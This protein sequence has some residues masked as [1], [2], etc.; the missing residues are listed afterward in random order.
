MSDL[1]HLSMD[2]SDE[3]RL[4][5]AE[6]ILRIRA[7]RWINYSRAESA[8]VR[9]AELLEYPQRDRMPCLLLFGAT[10]MGKTKILRK[11]LRD[12]PD[13]FDHSVGITT[14][15]VVSMQMPPEPDEKSFYEEMLGSLQAPVRVSTTTHHLRRVTRD[16]LRFVGARMIV[17]DEVH[18]LLAGSYRQQRVLLNTLRFLATD[19][20]VPLVCA[21]TADAKRAI[22]TDQQLAD[23]F[24]AVELPRWHNDE[25]F[26]RLLASFQSILPL[27][28]RSDLVSPMMRRLLLERTDGVTVRSVRL[29]EMMAVDAIRS[30]REKIDQESLLTTASAAPLISM[31]G[32]ANAPALS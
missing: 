26:H 9:M 11:F 23:R 15:Q 3:A 4:P 24:E 25:S 10:G 17:V 18:S 31:T 19:L 12:H 1:A 29:I 28:Q 2:G 7:D 8:L 13:V 5:D 21:G 32:D 6:R 22:T 16:L 27:R 14:S 30:G 20:R